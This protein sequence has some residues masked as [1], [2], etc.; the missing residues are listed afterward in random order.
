MGRS[1]RVRRSRQEQLRARRKSWARR[2]LVRYHPAVR[3]K[4]SLINA[5]QTADAWGSMAREMLAF[6]FLGDEPVV[7]LQWFEL[8][9]RAALTRRRLDE[10]EACVTGTAITRTARDVP[11]E[12][13]RQIFEDDLAGRS[14]AGK[15]ARR[16]EL[17][18]VCRHFSDAVSLVSQPT[19][20]VVRGPVAAS[21]L[22]PRLAVVAGPSPP[23][24][25]LSLVLADYDDQY[26]AWWLSL[27]AQIV[28]SS[29]PAL[30]HLEITHGPGFAGDRMIGDS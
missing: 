28:S 20:I 19:T 30:E 26:E 9:A 23:A 6:E 29:P 15:E 16:R 14:I 25:A 13:W 24:T 1:S 17:R 10:P 21:R 8:S 22:A 4:E 11:I 7:E 12:L 2:R 5:D 3:A 27:C 18:R